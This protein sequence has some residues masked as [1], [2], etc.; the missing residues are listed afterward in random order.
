M[1][2]QR[3]QRRTKS[4]SY[5]ILVIPHGHG[6][7]TKSIKAGGKE[8]ALWG[9]ALF[10]FFFLIF[11][12]AFRYTPLGTVVGVDPSLKAAADSVENE[13]QRRLR[14]LAE[15][16]AVVK[17]YN[18]QLRKALGERNLSTAAT[19]AEA[20]TTEAVQPSEPPAAAFTEEFT[21]PT[22][23]AMHVAANAEGLK[24]SFPLLTPVLG[25]LTRGFEPAR[26]HLGIDLA[27]KQGTPVHAAAEGYVVFAGWTFED[28]NV[29]ILSHGSGYMTVY[30]HNSSLL[31]STGSL[32]KRGEVIALVG[33]T[34]ITSKGP[35]LHFE[36]LKDGLP[37]DPQGYLLT[38]P[39]L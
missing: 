24:A 8:L 9:S 6:G 39:T 26:K 29:L 1:S 17:N 5:E 4:R 33:S 34:G 37:Q 30:K 12:L 13:T 11:F 23:A 20:R 28:G 32:V 31:K 25:V 21:P 19:P 36:V 16:V 15:E 14:A 22:P 38:A 35:H 27:A 2:L 10:L 7:R 3:A 18:I